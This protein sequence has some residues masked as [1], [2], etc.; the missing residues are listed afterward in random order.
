MKTIKQVLSSKG[1]VVWSVET[2]TSV[3]EAVTLMAE[4]NAGALLV[5]KNGGHIGIVTERDCAWRMTLED[6]PSRQTP[7]DQIMS[8]NI[9]CTNYDQ[10]I[11]E[12]MALIT[13]KR[14]RH[15]PVLDG[16][17]VVGMISIG[18]L[19]KSIIDDQ[20][21]MIEQLEHYIQT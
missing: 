1:N 5:T 13:E 17:Q 10:T 4:K 2:G 16:A 14:I 21:F 9:L 7:V 6:L 11:E 3:F 12:C 8:T 15:L 18:D 20:K 19:V